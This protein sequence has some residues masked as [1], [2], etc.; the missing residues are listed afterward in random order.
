MSS[1]QTTAHS[2]TENQEETYTDESSPDQYKTITLGLVPAP[3]LAE[4]FAYK[5]VEDLPQLLND[6]IDD[7]IHWKIKVLT[8]PLTGGTED[9]HEIMEKTEAF[10]QEHDWDYA[11]CITDLPI[12]SSGRLVVAEASNDR[13]SGYISFPSLGAFPLQRRLRES[14]F[15]LTSEIHHGSPAP[16]DLKD[17]NKKSRRELRKQRESKRLLGRSL[18]ERLSPIEKAH[19]N[20]DENDAGIRFYNKHKTTGRIRLLSGMALANSPWTIFS[21]FK[22]V[23]AVAFATG[24]YG[25]IFPTLWQLSDGYGIFRFIALMITAMV[26]MVIWIIV[27]HSLWEK[28]SRDS[29]S[30]FLVRLYNTATIITLGVA[31]LFYYVV[32]LILFLLAVVLFVPGNILEQ[33]LGHAPTVTTYVLLAW[34]ASSVAT[35]AGSLGAGLESEETILNA[36]YGYRQRRRRQEKQEDEEK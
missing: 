22:S 20:K 8:D 29:G 13:N 35:L 10:K 7:Q 14:I 34:L 5:L 4:K 15:Q 36:T 3:E 6:Q 11:I 2:D 18:T 24:S 12:L 17:E 31:V 25:L 19:F 30:R 16:E 28:H 27:A 33:N 26:A 21:S 1:H 23:I 32:I 9:A